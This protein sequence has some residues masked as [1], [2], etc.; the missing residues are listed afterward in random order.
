MTIEEI[1][2]VLYTDYATKPPVVIEASTFKDGNYYP[3]VTSYLLG[4]TSK[5]S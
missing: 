1:S 4:Y 2:E 3:T 5:K